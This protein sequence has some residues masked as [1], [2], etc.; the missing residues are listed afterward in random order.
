[1]PGEAVLSFAIARRRSWCKVGVRNIVVGSHGRVADQHALGSVGNA[2][3][4]PRGC[5]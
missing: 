4:R 5:H 2:V 1:M 3:L